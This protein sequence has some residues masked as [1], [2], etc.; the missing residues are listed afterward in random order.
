MGLFDVDEE[1][2][3]LQG[4]GGLFGGGPSAASDA[5]VVVK[6]L[7]GTALA[8]IPAPY[9]PHGDDELSERE[10]QDLE[11]CKAGVDNLRNAF[12]IAGKSLET[13]RT[14][15]LH[16]EEN[17]NFAE[18]VWGNWEISE[19]Q[20]YRLIDEWRVGEALANLGY[21]PLESQVRKLTELRR[22]TSDKVAITVYDTIARCVPRVTGEVVEGVVDQL[23][24]LSKDV[25]AA[26]VGRRVRELLASPEA[27]T[28]DASEGD[29]IPDIT[30]FGKDSPNGES[31]SE[32][33]NGKADPHAAKDIERLEAALA[34]LKEAAK[35]VNKPAAR[36]AVETQPDVAVPLIEAIGATLQQIDR[37][38]AVRRPK[39][40]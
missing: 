33:S 38:V 6:P 18:W 20:L 10:K 19:S 29:D 37:A 5:S 32:A 12:W 26:D 35:K 25:T 24:F 7:P 13:M 2:P 30:S 39:Q 40:G 9:Q 14:A 17:P 28:G 34:S 1:V 36:R 22:Q 11:A 4:T 27:G 15:Q 31:D 3:Q 16:R 8:L 23:G 21:K